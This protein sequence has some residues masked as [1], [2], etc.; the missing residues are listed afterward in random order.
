[1]PNE[2]CACV[3]CAKEQF[4]NNI[5]G[6]FMTHKKDLLPCLVTNSHETFA[7][8]RKADGTDLTE[9]CCCFGCKKSYKEKSKMRAHM[10]DNDDCVQKHM[11]F[12]TEIGFN[13]TRLSETLELRKQLRT[14]RAENEALKS[15]L[16][17]A[18]SETYGIVMIESLEKKLFQSESYIQMLIEHLRYVPSLMLK[19]EMWLYLNQFVHNL[20]ELESRPLPG[21]M[22]ADI[23]RAHL[24][25]LRTHPELQFYFLP[26][27]NFLKNQHVQN[28]EYQTIWGEYFTKLN[29]H[30]QDVPFGDYD[31]FPSLPSIPTDTASVAFLMNM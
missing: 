13:H 28:G 6:H 20:K 16:Q 21:E 24:D 26:D 5:C 9:Y 12:L 25:I 19:P 3:V 8:I 30:P 2:K 29:Y 18:R 1:M 17:E 14:L 31:K 7:I 15:Q 4:V 22:K 10:K 11:D 23:R 27:Y